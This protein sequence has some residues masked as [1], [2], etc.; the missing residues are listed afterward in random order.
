MSE[1]FI[2]LYPALPTFLISVGQGDKKK[3]VESAQAKHLKLLS[4]SVPHLSLGQHNLIGYNHI[5]KWSMQQLSNLP[6]D[7][8]PYVLHTKQTALSWNVTDNLGGGRWRGRI[9]PI[10]NKI[11]KYIPF[12][13]C[14]RN[15]GKKGAAL[16]AQLWIPETWP[17]LSF[18]LR[19]S[20]KSPSHKSS[21]CFLICFLESVNCLTLL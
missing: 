14:H 5:G 3:K 6:M 8:Q 18:P 19:C 10:W 21:S 13:P 11:E 15:P 4:C 1:P 9:S 2:R 12:A 7:I 16:C 17:E 20:P